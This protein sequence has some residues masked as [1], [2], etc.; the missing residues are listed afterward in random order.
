MMR[1]VDFGLQ[2]SVDRIPTIRGF[3]KT[4]IRKAKSIDGTTQL[5]GGALTQR[6]KTKRPAIV[7]LSALFNDS[8]GKR[9]GLCDSD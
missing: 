4:A 2:I 8:A 7:P 6:Q 3:R 5:G 9:D 1:E